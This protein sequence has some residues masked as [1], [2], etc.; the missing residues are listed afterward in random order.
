MQGISGKSREI[1]FNAQ[2]IQL[3]PHH[4]RR[5]ARKGKFPDLLI[6]TSW[7]PRFWGWGGGGALIKTFVEQTGAQDVHLGAQ[8]AANP[9]D[10]GNS[11][12]VSPCCVPFRSTYGV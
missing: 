1:A 11:G 8:P 5:D 10:S 6:S 7:E 2:E 12:T 3:L 4:S 9:G